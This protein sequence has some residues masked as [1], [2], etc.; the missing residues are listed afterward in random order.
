MCKWK[1]GVSQLQ[2][3]PSS[4]G[5]QAVHACQWKFDDTCRALGGRHKPSLQSSGL[6]FFV[7]H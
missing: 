2:A 6:G 7:C 4:R 3:A 5:A 1:C